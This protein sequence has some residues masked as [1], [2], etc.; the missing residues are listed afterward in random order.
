MSRIFTFIL[1]CTLIVVSMTSV[2]AQV[3]EATWQTLNTSL[4]KRH[5]IPAYQRLSD[6]SEQLAHQA[7]TL[8]SGS[9]NPEQLKHTQAAFRRAFLAWQGIQHV[10]F[11]AVAI[12]LRF[13]GYQ[14]WPDK[15]NIGGKQLRQALAQTDTAVDDEFFHHASVTLKGFSALEKLLF[16]AHNLSKGSRGCQL[17]VGIS[18]H[19]Q[20]NSQD[21]YREWQQA[22]P[23]LHVF[24][25]ASPYEDRADLTTELLKAWVEPIEAIRDNKI[26]RPLGKN[27][28]SA[29]W[30]RSEAWRSGESL[31][32]VRANIA[33][34]E[35]MYHGQGAVSIRSLIKQEAPAIE[36]N[37]RRALTKVKAQ[38]TQIQDIKNT[39][40][41]NEQYKQLSA[42]AVDLKALHQPLIQAMNALNVSL[43]FNSRDGD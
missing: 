18:G 5:I 15:K 19:N 22:L 11:G 14:Y 16:T 26:L 6:T 32:A 1:T 37:I 34:F 13:D 41:S 9:T 43:G 2:Q 17:L 31:N 28:A 42:L 10:R 29:R 4:V 23:N 30:K 27:F 40:L 12:L 25:D 35:D 36:Q 24:D 8:C 39:R 21:I 38:L 3:S 20:K 7:R 33:A